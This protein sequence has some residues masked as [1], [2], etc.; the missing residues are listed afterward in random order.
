M[1]PHLCTSYNKTIFFDIRIL[2]NLCSTCLLISPTVT[3]YVKYRRY[4]FY[5]A[6]YSCPGLIQ[7]SHRD[8]YFVSFWEYAWHEKV[9]KSANDFVGSSN[10]LIF[11]LFHLSEHCD[12]S[13]LS[14]SLY[15]FITLKLKIISRQHV[16]LPHTPVSFCVNSKKKVT[17]FVTTVCIY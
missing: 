16:F 7:V 1:K 4:V 5:F 12:F 2:L 3:M 6:T 15:L 9:L 10:I 13:Y 14:H 17:R 8:Q 11:I